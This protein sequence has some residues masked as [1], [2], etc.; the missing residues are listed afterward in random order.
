[1]E[2]VIAY[3][4]SPIPENPS[5]TTYCIANGMTNNEYIFIAA[6]DTETYSGFCVNK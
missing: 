5:T 6:T 1:M 4:A 3:C 2:S